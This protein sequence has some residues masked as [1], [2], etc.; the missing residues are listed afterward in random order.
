MVAVKTELSALAL[1][2]LVDADHCQNLKL[3]V[4]AYPKD[5]YWKKMAADISAWIDRE[6]DIS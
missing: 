3:P 1:A 6:L 2:L 4:T 5:Y